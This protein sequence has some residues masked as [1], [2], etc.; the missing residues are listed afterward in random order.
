MSTKKIKLNIVSKNSDTEKDSEGDPIPPP[1]P[2][3]DESSDDEE[4]ANIPKTPSGSPPPTPE[5]PIELLKEM[6][7]K[8]KMMEEDNGNLPESTTPDTPPE[9][10]KQLE[11]TKIT[12]KKK[13]Y[14]KKTEI[15]MPIIGETNLILPLKSVGKN[16]KEKISKN[17]SIKLEGKCNGDGFVKSGSLKVTTYSNG[18]LTSGDVKYKIVYEAYICNPVEGHLIE[19]N[20]NNVTKA[21]IRASV[22]DGEDTPLVIFIARDHHY[23]DSNFL[24]VKEG[25]N[26][27]VR[28]VG[29]RFELN[30][31]YI[32]II[33]ELVK[34]K[35][36][37]LKIVN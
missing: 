21:G 32:A 12:K 9:I 20:V 16:L 22:I 19:C 5:T 28:V 23:N 26:I 25:D 11:E 17:L 15:F 30:D 6:D 4:E 8:E 10:L 31:T 33:G 3:D 7:E 14:S 36:P 34:Q 29:S 1:P 35:K 24:S 37:R 2:T 18:L 13:E 27:T